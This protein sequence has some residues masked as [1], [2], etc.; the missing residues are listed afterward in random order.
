MSSAER[1]DRCCSDNFPIA[2][3]AEDRTVAG[4]LIITELKR[5]ICESSTSRTSPERKRRALARAR[6]G[7]YLKLRLIRLS[8][9]RFR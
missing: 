2:F 3:S 4:D 5:N 1:A 6:R 9:A 7:L 8:A